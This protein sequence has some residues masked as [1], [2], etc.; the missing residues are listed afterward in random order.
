[1]EYKEI[2]HESLNKKTKEEL[3]KI[4]SSLDKEVGS[5]EREL[6]EC[7]DRENELELLKFLYVDY[8]ATKKEN[9]SL[10]SSVSS[11]EHRCRN[12]EELCDRQQL[13]IDKVK[14]WK[15]L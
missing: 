7:K 4:I 8:V 9:Q 11:L 5:L 6:D 3:I 14:I 10:N 15:Y 13:F 12:L 2:N 1:M